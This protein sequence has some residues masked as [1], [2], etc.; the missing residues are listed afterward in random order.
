MAQG[1]AQL[2]EGRFERAAQSYRRARD[3]DEDRIAFRQAL[4][5][6]APKSALYDPVIAEKLLTTLRLESAGGPYAL[7]AEVLLGLMEEQRELSEESRA[8]HAERAQ[9]L[10]ELAQARGSAEEAKAHLEQ[11]INE[12][13]AE[14][15]AVREELQKERGAR[16]ELERI[17]AELDAMKRIDLG[18]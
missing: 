17:R 13:T 4:I 18:E 10:V 15:E 14:L 6:A 11:R 1:D 7:A 8:L 12:L 5:Y 3:A 9:H 16:V 2:A